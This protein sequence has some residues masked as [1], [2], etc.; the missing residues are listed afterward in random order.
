MT[1]RL[2]RVHFAVTPFRRSN[3]FLFLDGGRVAC[4]ADA[5]CPARSSTIVNLT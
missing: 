1:D 3:F 5:A 4:R 2:L